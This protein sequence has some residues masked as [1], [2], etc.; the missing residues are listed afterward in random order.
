MTPKLLAKKTPKESQVAGL[1]GFHLPGPNNP[2]VK[3]VSGPLSYL[4]TNRLYNEIKAAQYDKDYLT[5]SKMRKTLNGE[6]TRKGYV[7]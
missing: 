5:R 7:Q 3:A 2:V 1:G 6:D 4:V